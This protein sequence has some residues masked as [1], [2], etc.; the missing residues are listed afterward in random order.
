MGAWVGVWVGV[1]VC[2]DVDWWGAIDST[3]HA[4]QEEDGGI[5][6]CTSFDDERR[7]AK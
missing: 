6:D 1:Y 7:F 2:G 3:L 4:Q 5:K